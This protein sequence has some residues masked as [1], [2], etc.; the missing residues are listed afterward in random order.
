MSLKNAIVHE[1]LKLFSSKGYINTSINDILKAANSSKGGFYN[2]FNSKEDLFHETLDVAQ[3]IWREKTLYGIDDLDSPI[4][5]IIKILENYKDRYL[6]D[7]VNFPGGCIF[8]TFS[9]ELDDQHPHLAQKV[10]KGFIGLKALIKRLLEEGKSLGELR[11]DVNTNRATELI[12][13]GMVGTSVIY[14]VEKS[15]KSLDR[16]IKSLIDYLK[17][18]MQ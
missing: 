8:V 17:E 13:S 5:I 15:T 7:S 16:S 3:R 10:N 2:H 4:A 12:F 1:S 14:G 9:V 6:K 18:L 11:P